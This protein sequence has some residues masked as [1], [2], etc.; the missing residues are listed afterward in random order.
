[1]SVKRKVAVVVAD[2]AWETED[3]NLEV[4]SI[5]CRRNVL[6]ASYPKVD[7][8]DFV[9]H[10]H[11]GEMEWFMLDDEHQPVGTNGVVVGVVVLRV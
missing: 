1:M 8:E 11:V 2:V 10:V 9:S 7:G 4:G 3:L 5:T 6:G